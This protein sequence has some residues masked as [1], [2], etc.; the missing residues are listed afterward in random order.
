MPAADRSRRRGASGGL[1]AAPAE[2][3][4]WLELRPRTGRFRSQDG[5]LYLVGLNSGGFKRVRHTG[6]KVHLPVSLHAHEN[7]IRIRFNHPLNASTANDISSYTIHRWNYRWTDEYGSGFYS[8]KNPDLFGEDPVDVVSVTLLE[9]GQ[10]IF[11][12]LP[13]M[14]PVNQM[15]ISYE[16]EAADGTPL[17]EDIYNTI[18]AL[19][20]PFEL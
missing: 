11:L 16:L 2:G 10:E 7:G 4:S 1:G 3:L 13:E 6:E 5:Q 15:R 19:S 12:E 18:N 9:N 8:V 14:V 17:N 20:P